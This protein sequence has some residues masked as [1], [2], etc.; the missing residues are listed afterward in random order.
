MVHTP[1]K[2]GPGLMVT[3]VMETNQNKQTPEGH[4]EQYQ[5]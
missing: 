1:E 3:E 4:R 2:N 5:D